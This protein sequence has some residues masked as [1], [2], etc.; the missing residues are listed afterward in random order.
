MDGPQGT[1]VVKNLSFHAVNTEEAAQALLAQGTDLLKLIYILITWLL[2]ESVTTYVLFLIGEMNRKVA[3][4][5][6]SNRSSRSHAVFT[7]YL[8]S[9]KGDLLVR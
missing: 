3:E 2:S 5:A 8:S 7:V 9:R 1:A 6:M 4:T